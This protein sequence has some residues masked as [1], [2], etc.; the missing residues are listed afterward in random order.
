[1]FSIVLEKQT[2]APEGDIE[3][4]DS[5]EDVPALPPDLEHV[6]LVYEKL[7]TEESLQRSEEYCKFM[8]M[9]RTIRHFSTEDIPIKVMQNIIKTAG[10]QSTVSFLLH[11]S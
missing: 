10:K 1:M 8:N 11:T 7:A 6:P 3:E 5:E 2:I 4:F 9:R